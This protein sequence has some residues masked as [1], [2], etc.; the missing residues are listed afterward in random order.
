MTLG[1]MRELGVRGLSVHCLNPKC[2]HDAM[3]SV[4]DYA[5]EIEVTSF[6]PRMVCSKCGSDRVDVTPNW[7]ERPDMAAE[8]EAIERAIEQSRD[9]ARTSESDHGSEDQ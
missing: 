1:N 6:P 7:K 4:D 2:Q 5:D 9:Q 8:K 3:F